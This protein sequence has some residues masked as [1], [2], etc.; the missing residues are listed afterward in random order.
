MGKI[1][2][3]QDGFSAV[4]TV[5]ILVIVVLMGVVGFI[6]Y[7]NQNKKTTA[8]KPV[9]S[10]KPETK[11]E[12]KPAEKTDEYAGWKTYNSSTGSYSIKYPST[13]ILDSPPSGG[14]SGDVLLTSS[15]AKTESFGIWL[16]QSNSSSPTSSTY[17]AFTQVPYSQ[18]SV[19]QTLSNGIAVWEANQSL[20]ANGNTYP[21][22][23]TP[24]ESASGNAFGVKLRSGQ[25][26]DAA[27]SFCYAYG[28]S[29]AKNYAQQAQST[30][31]QQ[32][33]KVLSSLTQN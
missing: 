20:M 8:D 1:K 3:N 9:A 10:S 22:T 4:E 7:K 5:L 33:I 6:V 30:E 12:S 26:L 11:T 31:L 29:T 24:F 25:Y 16:N 13:W 2:N 14:N 17:S 18:G 27:M 21:D 15:G 23:C 19:L 32:A 28:Q